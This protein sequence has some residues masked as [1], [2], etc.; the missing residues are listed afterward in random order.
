MLCPVDLAPCERPE[1]RGGQCARADA[2]P[3]AMC[4]ECGCL[5]ESGI[6]AGVC[7]ACAAAYAPVRIEEE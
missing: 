1:C 5:D 6:V 3:L 2:A 7:V 4:W